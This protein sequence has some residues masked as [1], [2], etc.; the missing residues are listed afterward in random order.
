MW[1]VCIAEVTATLQLT[2]T[3]HGHFPSSR[4]VG[5]SPC[6]LLLSLTCSMPT[7]NGRGWA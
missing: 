6:P 2:G 5:Q 7:E 3:V 1:V 4:S